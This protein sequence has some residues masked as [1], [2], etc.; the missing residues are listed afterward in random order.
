[1]TAAIAL[2]G[3]AG[4]IAFIGVIFYI[5]LLVKLFQHGGVGL[6]ILGIFCGPFTYIWG[7]MKSSEFRLK[8]IMIWLTLTWVVSTLLYMVGSFMLAA[9]PEGQKFLKDLQEGK[10][11][12]WNIPASPS[13]PTIP[14]PTN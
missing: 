5:M 3:L 9:S 4:F 10:Q 13:A 11:V 1:M 2:W 6:G 7:W 14:E 8:K 12:E